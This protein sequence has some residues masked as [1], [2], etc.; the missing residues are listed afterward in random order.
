LVGTRSPEAIEVAV[1]EGTAKFAL[2][3]LSGGRLPVAEWVS[4][5]TGRYDGGDVVTDSA[6]TALVDVSGFGKPVPAA[7]SAG[8]VEGVSSGVV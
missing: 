2:F 1:A 4:I 7:R 5:A 6:N 8:I 3:R